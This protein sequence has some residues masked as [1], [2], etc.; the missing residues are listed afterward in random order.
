MS[1]N[2]GYH[3]GSQRVKGL[4][5]MGVLKNAFQKLL[6]KIAEEYK[7]K[8]TVMGGVNNG[9]VD[10]ADWTPEKVSAEVNRVLDW[11]DSPYLIPNCTFGGDISSF[12]GV[13]QAVTDAISA[14]NE[15]KYRW[16]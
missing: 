9:I 15:K 13:Y 14:Y 2:S 6:P 16:R 7:G 4:S 11:V 1:S 3:A 10:R 5:I 12:D 8:L